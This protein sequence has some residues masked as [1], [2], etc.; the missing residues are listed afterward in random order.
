M[1]L[2][3]AAADEQAAFVEEWQ[4][5]GDTVDNDR[6]HKRGFPAT[7]NAAG[8]D[9][10]SEPQDEEAYYKKQVRFRPQPPC[11]ELLCAFGCGR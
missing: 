1:R 7:Q 6:K 9:A 10:C 11:L 8:F 4:Q 3:T 5:L 2:K